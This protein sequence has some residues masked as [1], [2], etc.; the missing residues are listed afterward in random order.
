MI[1]NAFIIPIETFLQR[2]TSYVVDESI[3]K[4][5]TQLIAKY[6]CFNKVIYYHKGNAIKGPEKKRPLFKQEDKKPHKKSFTS[7]WNTLNETNYTKISHR[8]KF[9]IN[10][11][12]IATVIKELVQMSIVHSIYRKYFMLL[13][14]D[15]IKLATSQSN[16]I[17]II[18]KNVESFDTSYYLITD[19]DTVSPQYDDFCRL[20]KHKTKVLQTQAFLLDIIASD[21]QIPYTIEKYWA[22][23]WS[24]FEHVLDTEYYLD[25]YL[26]LVLHLLEALRSKTMLNICFLDC[27]KETLASVSDSGSMKLKFMIENIH[28]QLQQSYHL[29]D[30]Q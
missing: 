12:N 16:V 26:N 18:M 5:Y 8:L 9:M 7:L 29:L 23:V 20:Q 10:D 28:K 17:D 30:A 15:V 14:K 27:L 3:G 11:D 24:A 22:T 1:E 2:K 25:I 4:K 13:L 21:I 19:I 6:E